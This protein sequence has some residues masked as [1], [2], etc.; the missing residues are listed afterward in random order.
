[1]GLNYG[2]YASLYLILSLIFMM[3]RRVIPFFIEK[4]VDESFTPTNKHW[5][6]ISSLFLAY[7]LLKVMHLYPALAT[8]LATTLFLLHAYRLYGWHSRLE[9][10]CWLYLASY[11]LFNGCTKLFLQLLPL[12]ITT[13]FCIWWHRHDYCCNDG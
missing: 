4:G 1:M 12:L 8:L 7:T 9:P 3:A 13:C 10:I 2:L 11:W 6:D 5:L